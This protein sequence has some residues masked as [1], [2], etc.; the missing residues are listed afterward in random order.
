MIEESVTRVSMLACEH[1]CVM[2]GERHGRGK[3]DKHDKEVHEQT[4]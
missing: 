2:C 4:S 3:S 1:M